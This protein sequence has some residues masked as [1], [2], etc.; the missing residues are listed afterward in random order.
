MNVD[1]GI[2]YC[3]SLSALVNNTT[4]V[5]SLSTEQLDRIETAVNDLIQQFELDT[6]PVPVELMVQRPRPG[7][8][9]AIDLNELS[10][11]FIKVGHRYSPRMSIARLLARTALRSEWG[12]RFKL[13]EIIT[14]EPGLH[15]L[16]RAITMPK[17]MLDQLP[18]ASRNPDIVVMRF[19][20]PEDDAR[21]RLSDLGY[22]FG[23]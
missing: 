8:W 3:G 11:S 22:L 19:E 5:M 23:G 7:M 21:K 20:V 13:T 2:L 6:P 10:G 9:K 14:D 17:V 16:A 4:G 18:A 1:M 12:Q 15:T